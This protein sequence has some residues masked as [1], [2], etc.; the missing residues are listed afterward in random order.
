MIYA[1][2][3]DDT[4]FGGAGDDLVELGSGNDS[5]GTTG[6]DSAGT[7]SIYGEAGNDYRA[8]RFLTIFAGR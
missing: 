1:G 6:A 2:T 7:D 5:F 4:V 8:P 3:G